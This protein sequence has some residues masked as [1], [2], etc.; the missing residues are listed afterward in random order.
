MR[1]VASLGIRYPVVTD[2][3]YA[4]WNNYGNQSWPAD[5]L[6]DATGAVRF[7]S[8]GE[9]QY[10]ATESL[11][12]R[13]LTAAHPGRALPPASRQPSGPGRLGGCFP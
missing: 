1:E 4:T 10:P 6:I 3:D 2:N 9:G 12:R 11:I 7:T 8:A 5:Y 13:L